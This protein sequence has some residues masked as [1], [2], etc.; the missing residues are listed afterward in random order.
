MDVSSRPGESLPWDGQPATRIGVGPS[1]TS[2]SSLSAGPGPPPCGA[3]GRRRGRLEQSGG[4]PVVGSCGPAPPRA[5]PDRRHARWPA[6]VHRYRAE[7]LSTLR[8]HHLVA[9]NVAFDYASL[10]AA[11]RSP[12][13]ELLL[14]RH[15]HGFQRRPQLSASTPAAGDTCRHWVPQQRPHD[16]L[17]DVRVLTDTG[18]ALESARELMSGCR[19]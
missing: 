1:S 3:A 11:P 7:R 9:H 5:R 12:A 4:Q 13:A 14:T 18:A 15:V 19:T 2:R 8:A 16:A 6:T 10:A 17:T